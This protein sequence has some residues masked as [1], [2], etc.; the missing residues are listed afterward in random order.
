M[1]DKIPVFDGHNDVLLRLA[2]ERGGGRSFLERGTEGHLDLPRA[3]EGGLAGGLFAVFT[4]SASSPERIDRPDG[5]ET[6][7]PT[8]PDLATAQRNTLALAADLF[9][10]ER[11][12]QGAMRVCRNVAEIRGSIA[13]GALA[14]VLHIEGA[15]AIDDGFDGLEVFYRAG[16]R[17]LGLV[18]SRPN[19]FGT[20][21]PF[22][23][24][25][26][27]D[28]GPGLTNRGKELVRACNDLGVMVDLSHLNERGFWDVAGIS[29]KPLVAS[30][31]N[32]HAICPVPRNLTDAQL[33]A[34]A[35]S[36]GLVGVNFAVG[37]LD[38]GGSKDAGLPLE[39]MVR[40]VDHL[41]EKLGIEGVALGSD[42]DGATMPS[43]IGDVSGLP[44]LVEA[45]RAHGYDDQTLRRICLDNWLDVLER[46]WA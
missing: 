37:F 35:E 29:D 32:A 1:H 21:V 14:V 2:E 39:V 36:S 10:L 18:W 24:P 28:I 46:S 12:S 38:P 7:L 27:P 40:H 43:E 15:E 42:F 26:T 34:V 4:P 41:V 6:P 31:S 20:G 33:E 45:L 13:D 44:R 5:Y 17:S 9:R 3:R 22:N 25:G 19:A 8:A 11:D 23:Y 16:L 30:H